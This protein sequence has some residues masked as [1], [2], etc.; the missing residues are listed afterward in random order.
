MTSVALVTGVDGGIGAATARVLATAGYRVIGVDRGPEGT[1][2]RNGV[3]RYLQ[4]DL[5]SPE[6]VA[7]LCADVSAGERRLDVLVN[8]AAVQVAGS[9]TDTSVERWDEVMAVNVRAPFLLVRHLLDRLAAG[10]GGAVVNVASVHAVATSASIAAYAASK[11]ALA[12]LTRAL[13]VELAP[14]GVR[15]NAVLPGAVDTPMLEAGLRRGHLSGG[16]LGRLKEE[17]AGRTVAGRIGRPEEVAEAI[18]FLADGR[19]SGFVTGQQLV[20]DGG[21][22]ARLSTE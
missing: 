8:N 22:T 2:V 10:D 17:L 16:D 6:E 20:V 1:A 15:V 5:A 11:G 21:A 18:L 13:A 4:A 19:R 9:I 14:R 12:A 3:W 7:A